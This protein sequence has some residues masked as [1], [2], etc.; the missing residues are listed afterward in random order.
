MWQIF[1]IIIHG[2]VAFLFLVWIVQTVN[3]KEERSQ[4]VIEEKPKNDI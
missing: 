2:T 3:Y 4:E 1:A